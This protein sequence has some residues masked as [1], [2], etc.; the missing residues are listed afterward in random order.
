MAEEQ[1]PGAEEPG[2]EQDR[3]E[4][5]KSEQDPPAQ[6]PR[7][8]QDPPAQDSGPEQE[9]GASDD[10]AQAKART[11]CRSSTDKVMAGVAG[12]LGAYFGIDAVIVR[13][14]FIVL[15]FMGGAGPFLY[16]IGWLALPREDSPSVVAN[17]L[18]GDSPRRFRSLLAV[19]LIGLG[20]LI[21]ANLSG[22][23]FKLFINVWILAPFLALILI[24]AGVALV[25]WPGS[26][27]RP[28][29]TP[30]RPPAPDPPPP[31]SAY[32]T[33]TATPPTAAEPE[34]PP[35]A[36]ATAPPAR[37]RRGRSLVGTLTIAALLVYTGAAVVL[38]RLDA[39]E[40]DIGVYFA[41]AVAITGAGLL[42]SAFVRPAR[43]LILA[44]VVLSA[45][46]LLFTGAEMPWGSGV[47]E[48]RVTVT[49]I[50]ELQDEYRHGVGKL[51]VDLR[52]LDPDGTDN[53][54]DLSLSV[55]ELLVYVPDNISTTA[56]IDVG[57]G[58]IR[59]WYGGP[60]SQRR[61]DLSDSWPLLEEL[62][63]LPFG[64]GDGGGSDA[65][66]GTIE[67]YL[68]GFESYRESQ[69][70]PEERHYRE[71]R[72]P[73]AERQSLFRLVPDGADI[74]D[75]THFREV[76]RV[77]LEE[78]RGVGYPWEDSEDGLGL[79]RRITTPVWGEPE[80]ELRLDIDVG[81]GSVEIVTLPAGLP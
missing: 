73:P 6:E 79:A 41:T 21:T 56:D 12:G 24:A 15:T 37:R 19:G 34:W 71:T 32:A 2:A 10:G 50:D 40:V 4:Q 43:G 9:P 22:D 70:P 13:I 80:S 59:V 46:L 68:D 26:A 29:P 66:I 72:I 75:E 30:A 77:L 35:P 36:G 48:V 52:N 16:L 38:D 63:R 11:L 76:F 55:G 58:N 7:S 65:E 5:D 44:G 64:Y 60:A 17:A 28:K 51:V 23:L 42:A 1:R 69:I 20:L 31:S 3:P 61:Q 81:I 45:P 53:S 78:A 14:A 57:A 67:D 18:R 8:E 62:L 74:G 47:G 27:S 54:L 49:D 39:I 33:P 25:V